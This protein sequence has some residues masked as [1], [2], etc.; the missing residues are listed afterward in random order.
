MGVALLGLAG[1]A[2]AA[3]T[4][5]TTSASTTVSGNSTKSVT[6][7]C[8]TQS[9]YTVIAT[10]GGFGGGWD[11]F[12]LTESVMSG[13]G[14]RIT[15]KNLTSGSLPLYVY[16]NCLKWKGSPSNVTVSTYSITKVTVPNYASDSPSRY[17]TAKVTCSKGLLLSGGFLTDSSASDPA[18]ARIYENMRTYTAAGTSSTWQ[19][20]A[21]NTGNYST[22]SDKHITPYVYCLN[23][24]TGASSNETAHSLSPEGIS[25]AYCS[26]AKT[27]G[28][29]WNIVAAPDPSVDARV[30]VQCLSFSGT[31]YT[32]DM[33][34]YGDGDTPD[35]KNEA[36]AECLTAP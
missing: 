13:R 26:S 14:W 23:N 28:G 10:G 21:N 27:A 6:A 15:A 11:D 22:G 8:P 29:G 30:P 7:T 4:W 3:S 18:V 2:S 31:D 1:S 20:S 35:T 34:Y 33:D 16:A 19:I 9:G 36:H 25:S 24:Y 17:K 12:A 5:F 32:C